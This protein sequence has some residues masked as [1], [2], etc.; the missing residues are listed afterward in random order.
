MVLGQA[1]G[2]KKSKEMH[3]CYIYGKKSHIVKKNIGKILVDKPSRFK[4]LV[5]SRRVLCSFKHNCI[6]L[7]YKWV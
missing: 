1:K 3:S 6:Q 4:P 7:N 2:S 5:M